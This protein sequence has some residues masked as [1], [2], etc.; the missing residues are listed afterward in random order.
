MVGDLAGFAA[1]I[2]MRGI[3]FY[4]IPTTLLSQIDSSIGGKVAVDLDDIKNCVGAFHQPRRVLVDPDV[5]AT[6]P[7]RQMANGLA[8]AVKMALTF[9]AAL[10]E[11]MEQAEDP[12]A[13]IEA[14]MA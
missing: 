6:L 3:D 4:N 10:F 2:F 5:L 12:F 1:S 9:D 7:R 13:D 11:R 8:E 14:I